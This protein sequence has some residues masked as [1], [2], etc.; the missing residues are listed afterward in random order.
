[1]HDVETAVL[2]AGQVLLLGGY[3]GVDARKR[4]ASYF[5][6]W[7]LGGAVAGLFL[8]P[9]WWALRPLW[10]GE[11][12]RGGTP[13]LLLKHYALVW[14]VAGLLSIVLALAL[15]IYESQQAGTESEAGWVV[16]SSGLEV[17]GSGCYWIVPSVL[18]YVAAVFAREDVVERGPTGPLADQS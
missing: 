1:M 18:A 7:T 16:L 14:L 15:G 8:L 17:I 13:H 4:K 11:V 2:F 10:P 6:I 5:W 12:R 9:V 3:I